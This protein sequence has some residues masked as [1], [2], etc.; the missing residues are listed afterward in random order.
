MFYLFP[1][2]VGLRSIYLVILRA[3]LKP[4]EL[5]SGKTLRNEHEKVL[6]DL[7]RLSGFRCLVHD[8]SVSVYGV[9]CSLFAD[10]RIKF[11]IVL[12]KAGFLS[13]CAVEYDHSSYS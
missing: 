11:F 9:F 5:Y 8:Y 1:M 2:F 7:R 3:F 13:F 4:K 10:K 6:F 12:I